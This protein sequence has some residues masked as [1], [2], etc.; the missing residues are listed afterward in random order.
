MEKAEKVVRPVMVTIP[1][2][3]TREEVRALHVQAKAW[4]VPLVDYLRTYVVG[5]TASRD[6]LSKKMHTPE[7]CPWEKLK[8]SVELK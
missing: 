5:F 8:A 7:N 2:K 6:L 4:G 3:F 1:V